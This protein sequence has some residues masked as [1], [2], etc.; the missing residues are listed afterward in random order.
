MARGDL[1]VVINSETKAFAQ[2]VKTGIIAPL[3]DAE[4]ALQDLGR[5]SGAGQL[6]RDLRDA[7]KQTEQLS[8]ETKATARQIERSYRDAGRDIKKG[9]GDGLD[10]AKNEAKQSGREAAASFSGEWDDV[11]DFVQETMANAFEGFGPL[12]AAAG[13]AAAVGVGLVTAEIQKQQEMAEQLRERL[14][15]AWKDAATEGRAYLDTAQ[16][17]AEAEDL[18]FNTDRAEEYKTLLDDQKRIGADWYDIVAAHTGD[19]SAQRD[20]QDRINQ[21]VESEAGSYESIRDGISKTN[22]EVQAMADRWGLVIAESERASQAAQDYQEFVRQSGETQR[23]QIDRTAAASQAHYEAM[24]ARASQGI[25]VKFVPSTAAVDNYMA[26]LQRR[27]AQG[28]TV[29]VRPGQGRMWE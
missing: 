22:P 21:L 3:E 27:A 7:Q 25:P 19:L 16:I 18:M 9:V 5:S 23:E 29:N 11:G 2:G 8:D 15:S 6:E 4:Q 14:M 12:G 10:G 28:I 1:S 20:I 13:V 17:I 26:A 24:A